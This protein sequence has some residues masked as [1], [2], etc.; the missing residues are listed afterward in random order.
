MRI[1]K[2]CETCGKAFSVPL[3]RRE[4]ARF[5]SGSCRAT[6]VGSLP[7]NKAP[8]PRMIGNTLRR[9][10]T[11]TNAFKAGHATWNAGLKGIH[12]SPGSE[13]QP[14]RASLTRQPVGSVTIR[15]PRG[16]KRAYIK[17]AEPNVWRLR[18]V[19]A[20]EATNG[21]L[22]KGFVIH[23]RDRNTLNDAVDNLECLTKAEH[24]I[25]HQR[26]LREARW[27]VHAELARQQKSL[28]FPEE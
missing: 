7:H 4:S 26:E 12:L 14:G 8:K 20:W 13:F 9:G 5:C 25:D 2:T 1:A 17:V 27:P 24:A 3:Y 21:P 22:P 18:A 28:R 10:L 15:M 19:V 6:W 11:P 16:V 23:H